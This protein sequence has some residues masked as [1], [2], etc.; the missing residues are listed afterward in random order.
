MTTAIDGRALTP[1][2]N[3]SLSAQRD[4]LRRVLAHRGVEAEAVEEV[5]GG[6]V[7]ELKARGS[8]A[9][10][11]VIAVKRLLNEQDVASAHADQAFQAA[12]ASSEFNGAIVTLTIAQYYGIRLRATDFARPRYLERR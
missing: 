1:Q 12:G 7:A 10:A 11:V 9:G 5:L 2:V 6:Y 4:N 3:D 8:S